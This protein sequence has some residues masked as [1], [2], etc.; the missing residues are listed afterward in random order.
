MNN[1]THTAPT[2]THIVPTPEQMKAYV[3]DLDR[4]DRRT[5]WLVL[6]GVVL[7]VGLLNR[8]CDLLLGPEYRPQAETGEEEADTGFLRGR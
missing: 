8:G 4:K 1:E 7:L 2:T 3:E 5:G 6:G